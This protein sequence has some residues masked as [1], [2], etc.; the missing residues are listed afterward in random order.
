MANRIREV[1]AEKKVTLDELA[2]R[3]GTSKGQVAALQ[4]ERRQLTLSWLKRI[5]DALECKISDLLAD[6]DVAYRLTPSELAVLSAYSRVP[7]P[8]RTAATAVLAVLADPAARN[9]AL[10]EIRPLADI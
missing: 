7:E 5:A 4:A 2:E 9:A 3:L 8:Q 6:E 10:A 1:R